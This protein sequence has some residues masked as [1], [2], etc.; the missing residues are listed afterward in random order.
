MPYMSSGYASYSYRLFSLTEEN[1]G[2]PLVFQSGSFEGDYV[3][4]MSIDPDKLAAFQSQINALLADS[5]L[6]MST[7]G[8]T[9][10]SIGDPEHP[11]PAPAWSCQAE[12]N[13]FTQIQKLIHSSYTFT[14]EVVDT[15]GRQ[16]P[17]SI[18][19][20]SDSILM[21]M[22][23]ENP[24]GYDLFVCTFPADDA[25]LYHEGDSI[26]VTADGPL[27]RWELPDEGTH[28]SVTLD[29]HGPEENS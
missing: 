17:G 2:Q 7:N 11:I 16:K 25:S 18:M 3:D 27:Y 1:S 9:E 4:S 21:N 14:A 12:I 22:G 6:H 8:D 10:E 23:V 28:M 20:A 13:Y 24:Y 26:S 19:A 5:V 15:G 29:A